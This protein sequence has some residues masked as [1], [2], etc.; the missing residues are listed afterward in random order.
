[1]KKTLIFFLPLLAFILN[2]A[3][4]ENNGIS[5]IEGTL[6]R[7]EAK[8]IN[9]FK[10]ENG[11]L[12][13]LGSY[14]LEDDHKF[15]FAFAPEAEGFYVIGSGTA[16]QQQDKY[17]FYFKPGD[18]LNVS[19]N[20]STYTLTGSNTQENQEMEKWHNFV[21]ELEFKSVYFNK[22]LSNFEDFFPLIES[23]KIEIDNYNV[24][25]KGNKVFN[26]KFEE[27]RKLDFLNYAFGFNMKP[28]TKL[29][30]T[31]DFTE[32][33][34]TTS[35][36]DVTSSEEITNYPYSGYFI[37]VY[38]L[39]YPSLHRDQLTEEELKN[40]GSVFAILDR[41]LPEIKNELIQGEVALSWAERLNSY[42]EFVNF[43]EK[44]SNYFITEKQKKHF[45]SYLKKVANNTDNQVATDFTF[46]DINGK[47]VSLSDFQGKMVYIDVWATWC[48]PCIRE[49]PALKKVEEEYH[50]KDIVFMSISVDS[51]KDK[52]K[53]KDFVK[54]ENLVGVQ[55][56]AGNQSDDLL[57]LPYKIN[58]IPHFILIGKDGKIISAKAPRPSSS[59]IK[60]LLDKNL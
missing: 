40:Y 43:R 33:Y 1:M 24:D 27:Y 14:I 45:T 60:V 3:C 16:K 49:I 59:D 4:S 54:K 17:T 30:N 52:Q 46:E 35:L 6:N 58:A 37:Q 48:G 8:E 50:S 19:I 32:F 26:K 41:F 18:K 38:S 56:F 5:T 20:D 2:S 53:W 51:D 9:L 11:A 31:E 44:Y 7:G 22:T 39:I 55:L 36:A 23:K 57:M 12:L 10:V 47:K 25:Y 29:P 28:R 15:Y 21:Y 42:D 13:Q 34:K